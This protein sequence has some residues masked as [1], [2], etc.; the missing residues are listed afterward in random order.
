MAPEAACE[1]ALARCNV[2]ENK[3]TLSSH[4]KLWWS[5]TECS[6]VGKAV[7]LLCGL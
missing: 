6:K 3:C 1:Q 5:S 4:Q 2:N 7:W